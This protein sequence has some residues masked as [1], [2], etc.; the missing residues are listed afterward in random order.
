VVSKEQGKS[1]MEG[2]V[3]NYVFVEE[4]LQ[5]IKRGRL[6]EQDITTK[7]V[8]PML[9]ALNWNRYKFTVEGPEIHEKA[10]REKSDVGK[11]LPDITLK[12]ENGTVFVEVKRPGEIGKGMANLER[13]GDADLIV[14]T[15]FEDTRVY[16]RYRNQKP[17]KRFEF[18]FKQYVTEFDQLWKIL[19]NSKKGKSTRAAIKATR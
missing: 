3:K 11:G 17:R 10:F 2:L 1:M 15:T 4:T 5:L 18:N 8:L 14:L 12:S 6:S 7:F 16:T 13:Y 19:S 9:E